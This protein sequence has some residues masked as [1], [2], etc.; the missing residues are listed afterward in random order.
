MAVW[1]E[2][3]KL[4][5]A[6]SYGQAYT[7]LLG[8]PPKNAFE[9]CFAAALSQPVPFMTFWDSVP[10]GERLSDLILDLV[11]GGS[12]PQRPYSS[13][14]FLDYDVVRESYLSSF[15]R[16]KVPAKWPSRFTNS[17]SICL[18]PE[19]A[20]RGQTLRSTV[21]SLANDH[22]GGGPAQP[23]QANLFCLGGRYT[24]GIGKQGA[25]PRPPGTTC[26]LFVRSILHAAGINVIGP[27][28][29]KSCSCD[30]GLEAELAHLKCYTAT[31]NDEQMP[32]LKPGDVFHIQG[33]N[34]S[35]G[36]G[37]AHVGIVTSVA[38]NKWSC[39]Q[40]GASDHVTKS[41]TYTLKR[42]SDKSQGTWCFEE[43]YAGVKMIRG[44]RGYWNIDLVGAGNL[45]RGG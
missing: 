18:Y 15:E 3:T 27:N 12:M 1:D 31:K 5:A 2:F 25:N 43:D 35:G 21:V 39:V 11:Y 26:M 45:L 28:T 32:V 4:V 42:A 17:T 13:V 41:V 44:I 8:Q 6:G 37:S 7:W 34:F 22:S 38:G 40:G 16:T 29:P 14:G 23:W 9:G 30:K 36:Y 20:R 19:Y 33:K 24:F 10:M